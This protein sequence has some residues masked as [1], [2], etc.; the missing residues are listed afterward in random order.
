MFGLCIVLWF[1]YFFVIM[2]VCCMVGVCVMF[3]Y[4]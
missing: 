1:V 2:F 4:L 3:V